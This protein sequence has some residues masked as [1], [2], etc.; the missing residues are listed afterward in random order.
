MLF[1]GFLGRIS[2]FLGVA[3]GFVVAVDRRRG[4]LIAPSMRRRGSACPSSSFPDFVSPG[5]WS[6]IAMFLPVVL[7][8]VAENVGHVRGVATMTDASINK[9][10]GRALIADGVATTIAGGFGGSGTTTYGENIGV[11]AAT[12]VYSTAVYWVAGAFAI[13]LGV[14]AQGRRGVQLDPAGVLGGATTA[15]YGLIGIIGIKIWVDSRVDFSRPVNQYTGAVSLVIGIAGF[16]MQWGD[17]QFGAIVLGTVAALLIYHVGNA[18]ARWRKT[19]A[20]DGG[21]DRGSRSARRRPARH[22]RPVTDARGIRSGRRS[23]CRRR[24]L[25]ICMNAAVPADRIA[26]DTAMGAVTLL[27][28]DLDAMT[29]YYRDVVDPRG[30]GAPRATRVTLGRR[31]AGRSSCCVHEPGAAPRGAAGR[32]G[33]STRRSSSRRRLHS[34]RPLYSVARTAPGHVHRL[35]PT[36]S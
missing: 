24:Y 5:T 10:T 6:T 12:R 29:R 26:A 19:G 17:F 27:V 3:V 8:L 14:L 18:I 33:S 13:L 30:A 2:I 11:M 16:S 36:T 1:R 15:L 28:G 32:R 20:D 23:G 21:P 25:C 31:R 4:R 35:A 22:S 34:P 9:H 7:V